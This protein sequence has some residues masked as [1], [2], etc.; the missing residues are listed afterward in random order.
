M[1]VLVPASWLMAMTLTASEIRPPAWW[2][3]VQIPSV[4][5]RLRL[6]IGTAIVAGI[7]ICL[8]AVAVVPALQRR[9][10]VRPIAAQIDALVPKSET[11]YALDPDYQPFLFY[12]RSRLVYVSLSGF[13]QTG[14]YANRP[15]FDQ[16]AQGMGGLMSITGERDGQPGAGPQKVGI[17]A[18]IAQSET[19]S[20]YRIVVIVALTGWTTVARLV[21]AHIL[22]KVGKKRP[23][24]ERAM[25]RLDDLFD[26]L[27]VWTDTLA[28]SASTCV[29]L[30][31]DAVD[32]RKTRFANQVFPPSGRYVDA[33][34]EDGTEPFATLSLLDHYVRKAKVRT[35]VS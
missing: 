6:V 34:S 19:F 17:P 20:L 23:Q 26:L 14:P 2:R 30:V 32:A 12:I 1:P 33:I 15:G 31:K 28:H 21:R 22:Y 29:P 4:E 24:A 9:S 18:A 3:P 10:K 13:G 27:K 8:Y 11:L 16:V 25:N 5:R 7:A 35:E